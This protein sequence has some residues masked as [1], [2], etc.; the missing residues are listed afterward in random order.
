MDFNIFYTGIGSNYLQGHEHCIYTP[1]QFINIINSVRDQVDS[2]LPK[3][4]R[5]NYTLGNLHSLIK[6]CG[7]EYR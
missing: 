3:I 4:N 7:A 2:N 1:I 5:D 6:E